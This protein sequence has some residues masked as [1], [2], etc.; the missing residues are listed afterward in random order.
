VCSALGAGADDQESSVG[1]GGQLPGGEKGERRRAP[2]GESAAVQ[3]PEP[4]ARRGLDHYHLALYGR[5]ITLRVARMHRD[6][7]GDGELLI[8]GWHGQ[9]DA[10]LR[11]GERHPG[12]GLERARGALE[13]HFSDGLGQVHVRQACSRLLCA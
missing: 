13:R 3:D 2:G 5:K 6:E 8:G 4:T 12:R 1:M 7:L 11:Q 10:A 9:Q